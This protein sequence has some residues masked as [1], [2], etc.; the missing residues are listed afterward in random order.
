MF[1]IVIPSSLWKPKLQHWQTPTRNSVS[2]LRR[3][4]AQSSCVNPYSPSYQCIQKVITNLVLVKRTEQSIQFSE[5]GSTHSNSSDDLIEFILSDEE[6]FRSLEQPRQ[7]AKAPAIVSPP[8][9]PVD[10]KGSGERLCP[11]C[12]SW[13]RNM[14]TLQGAKHSTAIKFAGLGI[15][16][17]SNW[18]GWIDKHFKG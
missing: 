2:R 18:I 4:S 17:L 5:P 1:F 8:K 16:D 15:S 14:K 11:S 6:Y 10:N 12:P 3:V 13:S 9:S 7:N